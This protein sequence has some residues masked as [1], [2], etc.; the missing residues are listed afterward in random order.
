[1]CLIVPQS[2]QHQ[3][4]RRSPDSAPTS[5]SAWRP[6]PHRWIARAVAPPHGP[7][8]PLCPRP[9]QEPKPALQLAPVSA[10]TTP[11]A[12]GR[13]VA[14]CRPRSCF[15]LHLNRYSHVT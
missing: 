6:S 2:G 13:D 1:M 3:P 7:A 5:Q 12:L 10:G 4:P 14:L 9:Q 15:L 11:T 8:L